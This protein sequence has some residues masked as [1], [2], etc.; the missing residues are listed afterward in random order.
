MMRLKKEREK[1]PC[2]TKAT[3]LL[4]M[5]ELS[6]LK[7]TAKLQQR[8]YAAE[9]I[10]AVIAR[11]QERRFL[12][13]AEAAA[14]QVNY[15]YTDERLSMRAIRQKLRERGFSAEDID[16][17]W[18]EDRE[19]IDA[20]E[21]RAAKRALRGKKVDKGEDK[22]AQALYRRGFST[23]ICY[24]AVKEYIEENTGDDPAEEE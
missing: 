4:A 5:Q 17:A 10:E 11:L 16:S 9:E 23:S 18:P 19:E 22:L 21:L 7:L 2:W 20:R 14:R 24:R 3:E 6:S 12:N 1:P 13:D 8:G 15:F